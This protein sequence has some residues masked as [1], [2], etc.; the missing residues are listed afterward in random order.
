[1]QPAGQPVP[2]KQLIV[3][4]DDFGLDVAVNEAVE[5][6]CRDGILTCASLMV[7]APAAADAVERARRLPALRVG[8]HVVLVDGAPVLPPEQVPDLVGSDGRFDRRLVRAGFRFFFLPAVRRQLEREI[9]AQFEAFRATGL[10]LD[11]VNAHNHMHLH[12]TVAGLILRIG[13]AFGAR[14]VRVPREPRAVIDAAEGRGGGAGQGGSRGFS[15]LDL[16]TGLLRRR[17]AAAGMAVNDNVFGLA[18]SGAMTEERVLSLVDRLPDG[19]SELY[20][21]PATRRT[22][23]LV[24]AMPDYRHADEFAALVS[25]EVR[26]RVEASGARLVSYGDL[27]PAAAATAAS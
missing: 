17:L 23:P 16:W 7:G 19:V 2:R 4:A 27:V 15:P 22:P 13:R 21:H 25:G 14:A 1:M 8:L 20:F 11:H 10:P 24:R 6:G 18:W 26:R 3:C 12:P 9:R 5:A